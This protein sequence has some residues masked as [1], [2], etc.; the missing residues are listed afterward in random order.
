MTINFLQGN[1]KYKLH[2]V[3]ILK[4]TSMFNFA[5]GIAKK[6][7]REDTIRKVVLI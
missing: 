6:F 3:Y 4:A 5:F 7:M 2:Q 1:Y